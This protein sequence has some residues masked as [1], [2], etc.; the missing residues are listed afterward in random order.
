MRC[1]VSL[2][3][4]HFYGV[5]A[6]PRCCFSFLFDT[7]GKPSKTG[8]APQILVSWAVFLS[9]IHYNTCTTPSCTILRYQW[10]SHRAA[11]GMHPSMDRKGCR[12]DL[13]DSREGSRG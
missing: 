8:I 3:W 6:L 2:G 4:L 11:R 10:W 5:S 9:R 1:T 12:C 13:Q 7:R